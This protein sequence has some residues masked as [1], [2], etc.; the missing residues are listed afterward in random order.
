VSVA[1]FIAAQRTDHH[2]PHAVACRALGVSQSWFYKWRDRPAT[3]RQKR[4]S[5]LAAALRK[6]FDDSGGTYG[7]PRIGDELRD[8]GWQ[9]SDNTIALLMVELGLVARAKRRRRGL[10]R[11]G[12]RPAG[13]GPVSLAGVDPDPNALARRAQARRSITLVVHMSSSEERWRLARIAVKAGEPPQNDRPLIAV[14]GPAAGR[15]A[16]PGPARRRSG[17]RD[18]RDSV[19]GSPS[20]GGCGRPSR[21]PSTGLAEQT[22]ARPASDRTCVKVRLTWRAGRRPAP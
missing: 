14:D 19:G 18:G 7:S 10:T 17:S 6:V 9:V 4:R 8:Q 12:L 15:A 20:V 13:P 16:R 5:T 22:T 1:G 3:L 21:Q 11:P 2:V